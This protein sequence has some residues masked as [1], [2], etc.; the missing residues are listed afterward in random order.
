M[1]SLIKGRPFSSRAE[2]EPFSEKCFPRWDSST[3]AKSMA[4]ICRR[5]YFCDGP[6]LYQEI[7][8][9]HILVTA[10][11]ILYESVVN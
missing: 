8:D 4:L 1:S 5:M 9:W 3:K 11:N 10:A 2:Y 7:G 6:E